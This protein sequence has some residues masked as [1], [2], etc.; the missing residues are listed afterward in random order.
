MNFNQGVEMKNL[1]ILAI[2]TLLTACA[3]SGTNLV[4]N[5]TT[6]VDMQASQ[7]MSIVKVNVKQA[8]GKLPIVKGLVVRESNRRFA[9][10]YVTVDLY[11]ERGVR[12]D[13]IDAKVYYKRHGSKS[14]RQGR[15]AAQLEEEVPMNSRIVVRPHDK[16]IDSEGGSGTMSIL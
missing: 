12:I 10:G 5:G 11:N 4:E 15:F 14:T 1:S 2:F 7:K 6:D 9:K 13:S 8:E 3:T 16:R